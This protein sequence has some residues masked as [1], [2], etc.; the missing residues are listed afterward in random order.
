[1]QRIPYNWYKRALTDPYTQTSVTADTTYAATIRPQFASVGG[2]NGKVNTFK[3]VD[4]EQ[5]SNG[6]FNSKNLLK[7]NNLACFAYGFQAQASPDLIKCSGAIANAEAMT[8]KLQGAFGKVLADLKC[9][10]LK[11]FDNKQFKSF[12]GY[13]KLNCKTGMY[14]Q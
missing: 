10:K 5:F 3:G 9:P 13:T 11:G 12:P 14:T 6:V 8:K 1:M 2:N 7:G 4:I